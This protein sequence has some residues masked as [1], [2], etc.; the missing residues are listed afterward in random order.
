M[1]FGSGLNSGLNNPIGI[2]IDST[3][4]YWAEYSGGTVNPVRSFLRLKLTP[5]E[6]DGSPILGLLTG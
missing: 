1:R 5:V 4:V 3:K 2:A 6:G